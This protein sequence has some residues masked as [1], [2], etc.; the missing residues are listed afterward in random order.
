MSMFSV[1]N[2]LPEWSK[3]IVAK[4]RWETLEDFVY[5]FDDVNI[6]DSLTQ[7]LLTTTLKDNRLVRSRLKAARPA[8]L[9]AIKTAAA[10]QKVYPASLNPSPP[11]SGQTGFWRAAGVSDGGRTGSPDSGRPLLG[12]ADL[13]LC[14][15]LGWPLQAA[16]LRQAG[17]RFHALGPSTGLRG[18]CFAINDG[19]WPW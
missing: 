8:G 10:E 5:W 11:G 14:L 17:P 18:P 1:A 7:V 12:A 2:I 15:G 3:E 13:S 6:E 19:V 4:H 9:A 16:G